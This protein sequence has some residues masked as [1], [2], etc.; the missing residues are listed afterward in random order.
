MN[1]L[2]DMCASD[3]LNRVRH[4]I[5]VL[6]SMDNP[7]RSALS[8][9]AWTL[10]ERMEDALETLRGERSNEQEEHGIDWHAFRIRVEAVA[11]L[12]GV[13]A[14]HLLALSDAELDETPE[15]NDFARETGAS[16]DWL[17]CG[18]FQ[19]FVHRRPVHSAD[20]KVRQ[21]VEA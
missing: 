9:F 4:L 8:E 5:N 17:I 3:K 19:P 14:S 2:D 10:R 15:V 12:R 21:E 18:R 6:G 1:S 11:A 20:V 16:L 7:D 13:D